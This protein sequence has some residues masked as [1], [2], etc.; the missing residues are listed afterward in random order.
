MF[1]LDYSRFWEILLKERE[2]KINKSNNQ[3]I[4]KPCRIFSYY[5]LIF[6]I[7]FSTLSYFYDNHIFCLVNAIIYLIA[8]IVPHLSFKNE[9]NKN[10]KEQELIIE[11]THPRY[12]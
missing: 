11:A 7:F 10:K 4:I 2:E 9:Q 3:W 5:F 12:S 1:A 8:G 6:S